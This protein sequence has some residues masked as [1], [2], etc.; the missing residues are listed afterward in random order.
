MAQHEAAMGPSEPAAPKLVQI[1]DLPPAAAPPERR[2]A[3]M[4]PG[5]E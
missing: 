4:P 1:I 3:Q 2:Q 5:D